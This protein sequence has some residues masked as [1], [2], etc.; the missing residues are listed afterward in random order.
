M[1]LFEGKSANERNKII[2]ASVLGF[3]AIIS[4]FFAFGRGMFTSSATSVTVASASPTPKSAASP[5]A[6]ANDFK[7]P[8]KSEQDFQ[9][10]TTPVVYDPNQHW[11][12]D[13]GRNIFAFYEPPPPT[14]YVP[15]P[16][17]TP[18]PKP[19]TPTPTPPYIITGVSP[20]SIY[21]GSKT[22]RM[23]IA[24][25]KFDTEARIY[26][27]QQELPTTYAG[28]QRLIAEVP[29]GYI[30]GEGSR[31]II[32]QSVDGTKYSL[33]VMF[34]VQAPPKPQFQYIGMIARTR[35]NNDTAYF[36]EQGKPTPMSAR[37]NDVVGGR[38]RLMSVSAEE[39]ILEDVNLG[40]RHKL[41]LYRPPPGTPI[42]NAPI[43]RGG[44]PVREDFTP[45][46]NATPN[47]NVVVPQSIPGI[48]NNIPRYMPPGNGNTNTAQPQ[49]G[50]QPKKPNDDDDDDDDDGKP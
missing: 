1:K 5:N 36:L 11:A 32:V 44:L 23:E 34:N 40:F 37:L 6:T 17:I 24:G 25:D 41:A 43:T 7:L 8:S 30:S 29:N 2:A 10:V 45:Q 46:Y 49:P 28:P 13:P 47:Y 33:P 18:T 15:T 35:H 16:T 19:P 42:T 22:F 38:F 27:S 50:R 9:S 31:Q 12:P 4:L 48:P 3:L 14:P 39:T 20:E 21:A 26:F